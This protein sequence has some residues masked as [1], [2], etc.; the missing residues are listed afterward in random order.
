MCIFNILNLRF[1][2]LQKKF[3]SLL[4]GVDFRNYLHQGGDENIANNTFGLQKALGLNQ[5]MP[6]FPIQIISVSFDMI[7]PQPKSS[8]F[9]LIAVD[10]DAEFYGSFVHFSCE[11]TRMIQIILNCNSGFKEGVSPRIHRLE[12]IDGIPCDPIDLQYITTSN[13]RITSIFVL[14]SGGGIL[15][16]LVVFPNEFGEFQYVSV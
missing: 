2:N 7:P 11:S 12:I 9:S 15:S 8:H 4:L 6:R 3:D 1:Y 5:T 10:S 16:H 14:V 13:P